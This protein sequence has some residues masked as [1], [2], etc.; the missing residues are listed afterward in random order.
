MPEPPAAAE[1]EPSE[2]GVCPTQMI[3]SPETTPPLRPSVTVT[4]TVVVP[5][6]D[7]ALVPVTVYVVVADGL[8]ETVTPDVAERP[9][10]GDHV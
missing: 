3:W 6:H 2:V 9:V 8:A 5:V 4:V 10:E 7:A 1:V